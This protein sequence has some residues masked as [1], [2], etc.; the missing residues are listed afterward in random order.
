[1]NTSR[2]IICSGVL[3]LCIVLSGFIVNSS[4][5][6]NTVAGKSF[7]DTT[8]FAPNIA[9]GWGVLA[10]SYLNQDTPDSVSLWIILKRNGRIDKINDHLIG[11]ITNPAFRPAKNQMVDYYLLHDNVWF[12]RITKDGECYLKQDRG[13]SLKPSKLAGN[14]DIIPIN[15]RYKS[16]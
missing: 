9:G 15:I 1:M 13:Q 4:Y 5:V 6:S 14:P 12:I 3:L 11:T 7:G 16:N 10:S 2:F 8:S